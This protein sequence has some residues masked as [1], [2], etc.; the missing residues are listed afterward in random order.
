M[1]F[2]MFNLLEYHDPE[3][4]ASADSAEDGELSPGTALRGLAPR[5]FP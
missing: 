1:G 4:A 2:G 5:D 3:N